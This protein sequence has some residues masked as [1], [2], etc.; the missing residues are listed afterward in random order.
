MTPS[1]PILP[2]GSSTSSD[3]DTRV[4]ICEDDD[5]L[6]DILVQGLV[7]FGYRTHGVGD[8]AA[9]DLSIEEHPA[10]IVILDIGLPGEDGFSIA[11]RLR[12]KYPSLG[13]VMLT[14]RDPI[15]DRVKGLSEGADY[16]YVKPIDLREL[17]SA[18]GSLCRRLQAPRHIGWRLGHTRSTLISPS[19]GETELTDR[20]MAFLNKLLEVPGASVSRNEIL[21][22]L[23]EQEDFYAE[24]RLET[25]I[26][27]LRAKVRKTCPN[28]PLPIRARH[29]SGYAFLDTRDCA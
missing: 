8:G 4:L 1:T 14:A 25:M 10:D 27:R 3:Q 17:A 20:E 11:A 28:E 5:D 21:H 22:G 26:S 6:R 9:L 15:E 16:Y 24:R 23:G 7:Y 29:G 12:R 2:T 18:L 13:I 19:G